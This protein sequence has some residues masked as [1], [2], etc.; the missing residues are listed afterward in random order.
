M[1]GAKFDAS[2]GSWNKSFFRPA[3]AKP[4]TQPAVHHMALLFKGAVE[5]KRL[6][7][8][9]MLAVGL[10]LGCLTTAQAADKQPNIVI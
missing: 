5:M 7:S 3:S 2:S 1:G 4:S 10:A 8:F 9:F 6:F